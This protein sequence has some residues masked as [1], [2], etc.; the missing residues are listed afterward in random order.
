MIHIIQT[1]RG[2]SLSCVHIAPS[3]GV[4]WDVFGQSES[5]LVFL[6]GPVA[7]WLK[8]VLE[9]VWGFD[10]YNKH[11][12]FAGEQTCFFA[13]IGYGMGVGFQTIGGL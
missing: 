13:I 6:F 4:S 5:G 12:G 3:G 7:A 1:C 9:R 11:E 2:F 10:G 8:G